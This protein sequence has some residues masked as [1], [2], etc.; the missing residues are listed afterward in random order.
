[1]I[2]PTPIHLEYR[3][4]ADLQPYERELRKRNQ[5][6]R[7]RMRASL[8]EFGFRIPA[9]VSGNT[10]IDG[11]LRIEAAIE[12]G[13]TEIPVIPC[14]DWNPTQIRAF[15]LMANRSANWAEFDLQLVA[16][17]IQE[18]KALDFNLD[19][20]GFTEVEINRFL[21]PAE[22]AESIP[23]PTH[24]AVTQPG[25]VWLLGSHRVL[26]GDATSDETVS[27]LLQSA[28]PVLMVTDP[29]YGVEYDPSWR[30]RA[31]LGRQRQTG[32]VPNDDR[33]DWS[34]AYRLF[35]GDIAYVWHAGVHAAEVAAGLEAAGLRIRAQI[36]WAKQHFA[37][38]RGDYHWQHEPCW[39]CVREGKGSNWCADRKQSTLWEVPNLNPFGGAGDESATGH[40]TQKPIELMRRPLLHNTQSGDSVYDP[41]LGS[42]TTLIAAELTQRI[43]YGLEIDP[44]YVDIV[45][46]RWQRLTGN[47][48][49]LQSDGRPFEEVS[50][51]R[52][53][54]PA[55]EASDA[56]SKT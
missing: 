51:E 28:T 19:L 4:P 21:A 37:L 14:D 41:F 32:T 12:E 8:R 56:A 15:R 17:E 9:L 22:S 3:R 50:A 33:A 16:L 27:R 43:C 46:T 31:G 42:G 2:S 45:V 29:P 44:G 13:Y 26:C 5:A 49:T 30:E 18:L 47:R 55:V 6:A 48:A 24:E 39:Y 36:I 1:M 7:N 38:G 20:T 54:V 52:V 25:D 40:G 23:E 53:S 11:Q 34:S 35:R 10:I